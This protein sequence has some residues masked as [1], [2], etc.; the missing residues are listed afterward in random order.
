[1]DRL[2]NLIELDL[3]NNSISKIHGLNALGNLRKLVLTCNRIQTV[4]A[5]SC[6]KTLQHLFLQK[7][8]IVKMDNLNLAMLSGVKS[9]R[10]LYLRNIDGAEVCIHHP[11][12]F[13]GSS[14]LPLYRK[15]AVHFAGMSSMFSQGVQSGCAVS[16]ATLNEPGWGT[17]SSHLCLP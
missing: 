7:N 4:E 2:V 16:A 13:R 17:K 14:S 3:S 12:K 11:Q 6:V 8:P 9:L 10:S 15:C 1:M 5:L